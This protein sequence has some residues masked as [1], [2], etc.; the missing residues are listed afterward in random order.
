VY[1]LKSQL[2]LFFK[3]VCINSLVYQD[4]LK[5]PT[6]LH[7]GRGLPLHQTQILAPVNMAYGSDAL[8]AVTAMWVLTVLTLVFVILRTYTRAHVV[9]A[10]GIDDHVYNLAFVR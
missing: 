4:Q 1:D 8:S 9:K 6:S 10:Y 5:T 3:F 2:Q 7:L